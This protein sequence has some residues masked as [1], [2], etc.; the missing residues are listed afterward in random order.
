MASASAAGIGGNLG[1]YRFFHCHIQKFSDIE[2]KTDFLADK[3]IDF[4]I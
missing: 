2:V 4:S 3:F 1:I